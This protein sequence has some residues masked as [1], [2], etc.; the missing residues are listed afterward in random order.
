MYERSRL[1]S[2][3][4][5]SSALWSHRVMDSGGGEDG[6]AWDLGRETGHW[7]RAL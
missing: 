3:P 6:T 5:P 4:P 7:R 1:K 2:L